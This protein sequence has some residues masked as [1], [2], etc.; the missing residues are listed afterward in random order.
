DTSFSRDL[1]S[2][3]CSSDL[4]RREQE[5]RERA[6][7]EALSNALA[8]AAEAEACGDDE[9]ALLRLEQARMLGGEVEEALGRVRERLAAQE[10]ER[11]RKSVVVGKPGRGDRA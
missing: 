1:S 2:E 4:S 5:A 11:G 6:R 3:L 7:R 8:Q 9:T 10:R